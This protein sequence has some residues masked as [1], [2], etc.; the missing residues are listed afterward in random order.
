[1]RSTSTSLNDT[2]HQS[3]AALVAGGTLITTETA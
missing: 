2:P 3:K 1:M